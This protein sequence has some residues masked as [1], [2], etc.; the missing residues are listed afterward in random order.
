MR[1]LVARLGIKNPTTLE[2]RFDC[3]EESP[4]LNSGIP[5]S[6]TSI[7]ESAS[8]ATGADAPVRSAGGWTFQVSER[9]G[10]V[11]KFRGYQS[12]VLQ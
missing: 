3:Y 6:I 9:I 5:A 2:T 8:L 4:L 10:G 7:N 1:P 12:F 11:L